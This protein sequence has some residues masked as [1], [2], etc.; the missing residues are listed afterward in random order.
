MADTC[1]VCSDSLPANRRKYCSDLCYY[2]ANRRQTRELNT[3]SPIGDDG[4]HGGGRSPG[5]QD[6]IDEDTAVA[7]WAFRAGVPGPVLAKL[8]DKEPYQFTSYLNRSGDPGWASPTCVPSVLH[9]LFGGNFPHPRS[10]PER[11][12]RFYAKHYGYA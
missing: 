12:R 8:W 3:E 5:E 7:C 1:H 10:G 9:R 4:K 11:R 2:V 6:V